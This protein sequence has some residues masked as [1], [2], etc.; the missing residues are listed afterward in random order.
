MIIGIDP[1]KSGGLVL[2]QPTVGGLEP[3]EIKKMP[4]GEDA[5][6]GLLR[7]WCGIATHAYIE[8][9]PKFA[10]ENRSAAFM[11]VLYGNYKFVCGA[12][13]MHGKPALEEMPLLKWMNH[14]IPMK[15]RSRDRTERKKQLLQAAQS[16]WPKHKWNLATCDA[17]LIAKAGHELRS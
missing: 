16:A 12:I 8:A 3:V 11:A 4:E 1:G 9:I 10:G 14:T 5:L 7:E 15:T 2:L 13:R 17:A 6:T